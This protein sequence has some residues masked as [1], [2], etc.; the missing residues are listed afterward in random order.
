MYQLNFPNGNVQTYNNYN[1]LLRAARDFGGEAKII[2]GKIY[3]F[4]PKK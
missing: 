1:D 4:V 3:A 2:S